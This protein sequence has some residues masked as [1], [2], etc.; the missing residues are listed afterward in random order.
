MTRLEYERLWAYAAEAR[1]ALNLIVNNPRASGL[2]QPEADAMF[3]ET[4]DEIGEFFQSMSA[5]YGDEVF[6]WHMGDDGRD[7]LPPADNPFF[8]PKHSRRP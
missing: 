1:E 6:E 2:G 5:K 8:R 7:S 4:I 3:R